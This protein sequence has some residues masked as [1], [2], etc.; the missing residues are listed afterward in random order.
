[1]RK[2][3]YIIIGAGMGG[4][5]TANFLA[6]F[7]KKVLVLEK[8][9]IPG[10]LVTSFKRNGIS[11]NLGI[12]SLHELKPRDTIQQFF[13]FWGDIIKAQKHSK[14][15][16]CFID[17]DRYLIKGES[18][19]ESLKQ[20][21][22]QNK[23]DIDCIFNINQAIYD[24]LHSG[25]SAPKP[26]YE[27]SLLQKMRFAVSQIRNSPNFMKYGMKNYQKVLD[28]LTSNRQLK[29]II[30]SKAMAEMI[31][32][33]YAYLWDVSCRGETY[34]PIGGMQTIPD[35]AVE[36]LKKL[37]GELILKTQV[38]KIITEGSKAIGV[39]C[40]NGESYYAN[41]VISN[42]SPH[43]TLDMLPDQLEAKQKL[44]KS[45]KRR[46]IF[47][48]ACIM[49]MGIDGDYDFTDLGSIYI[50]DSDVINKDTSEYN[51]ETCPIN[52]IVQ[53]KQDD[54]YAV[55]AVAPLPYEY[56]DCW[57][58]KSGRGEEYRILKQRVK[59]TL[60][61]RIC[62][63]LGSSFSENILF[64]EIST[65]ITYER[66]THNKNGS[67]MGWAIDQKN[68]GKFLR[69][70]TLID[71]LHMV[72]QWVFPGFGIAGVMASGYF[73]AKDLLEED[74]INLENEIANHTRV[75]K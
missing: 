24:E 74:D 2:Y 70:H 1:M 46:P 17:N 6:K 54:H 31:Y 69:Q 28:K 32:M 61:K 66:Y 51:P 30:F 39:H 20:C 43:Y 47:Q 34:Y 71:N 35:T 14:N 45:I 18:I 21:F 38:T 29:T 64:S 56:E 5:S 42:C 40:K 9:N 36:L 25:D 58:A 13:E 16:L 63:K 11:F 75:S 57:H 23:E 72:G 55:C 67:F 19:K 12:E 7:G 65:P 37:G 48:S 22:P 52:I 3:D 15:M 62:E 59:D 68:Y 10:G 44:Y 33:G 4:L 27:M 8:H 26:P 49:F 53:P 73:L 41:H 60:L 50:A